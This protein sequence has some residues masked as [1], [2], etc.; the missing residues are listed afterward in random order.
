M[1]KE[2]YYKELS[3]EQVAD[4]QRAFLT[5]VYSWMVG[6]LGITT[7]TAWWANSSGLDVSIALGG[8]SL[9]LIILQFGLVFALS[10]AINK[11]SQTVAMI[12]F[13]AYSFLTGLTFSVILMAYTTEAIYNT[14]L[15]TASMFGALSLYGFVTKKNLSG[16]GS[17]MFMGL[18]G[19]IIAAVLNMFIASSALGFVINVIGVVVFAG[20]TAYDTQRL[21][22]MHYLM[23]QGE[24]I[25]TKGAILGALRLYLDFINLF[26]L[27]LSFFGGSRD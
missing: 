1:E 13:I 20:L 6:G 8:Y 18:I 23:L 15:V 7:L 10:A 24:E 14:F 17:F 5:K 19:I 25:A 27:L 11:M 3:N 9:F 4:A 26:L 16:L 21:K 22:E 2:V 12:S